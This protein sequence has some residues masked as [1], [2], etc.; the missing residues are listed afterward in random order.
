MLPGTAGYMTVMANHCAEFIAH[1]R[2]RTGILEGN[3]IHG[4]MVYAARKVGLA[5]IC[6]VVIDSEKRIAAAFS[7]DMEKGSRCGLFLRWKVRESQGCS[8]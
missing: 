4:D 3:P 7:G 1:E 5:F 8:S 6:N 2:A